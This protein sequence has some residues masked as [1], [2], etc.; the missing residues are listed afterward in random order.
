MKGRILLPNSDEAFFEQ[1]PDR[2]VRI[3]KP[4]HEREYE[5]EFQTLGDHEVKR[6]RIIALRVQPGRM[7]GRIGQPIIC[8]PFLVYADEDIADDDAT[9]MP[10]ID[11]LMEEAAEGYGIKTPRR[12]K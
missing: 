10:I 11:R 4:F 2:R 6:R 1:H 12:R 3:R 9:L 8:I 7:F 5:A